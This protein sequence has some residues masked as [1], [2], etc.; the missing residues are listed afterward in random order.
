MRP[1]NASYHLAALFLLAGTAISAAA[2]I[3]LSAT[4]TVQTQQSVNQLVPFQALGAG[5][6]GHQRGDCVKMFS[7][8]AMAEM[9][10]AGLGP[11][12][13]RLRTE[14]GCEVWHWNP[15]G[16]WSDAQ[17]ECGYWISDASPG[18]PINVSYGYRLPRRGNSIDQANNDGYSRLVDGDSASFWKS[19][20]Y[21]DAHFTGESAGANPQWIIIDL[22]KAEPV[23]GLKLHWGQPFAETLRAEYWVGNDPMHLHSDQKGEWRTFAHGEINHG[24]GGDQQTRLE[25]QGRKVRFVRLVLG[26]SSHTAVDS[27]SNDIRDKLGFAI[28][29]IELGTFDQHEKFHDLLTHTA[30]GHKQT[31]V[32][33][34]ST[35]PWHRVTDID[36]RTEQPGLDFI[37]TSPLVQDRKV[38]VPVAVFYET[39]ENAAAEIK[40]L[41]QRNYPIDRIELG[42]EP[43]GQWAIPED[44][45]ALYAQVARQLREE[46]ADLKIGGPSLQS[47]EF[48]LLTWPDAA[49][50]SSWM[51]RFINQLRKAK[52]PFDFFS[53]E[54][55]PFDDIWADPAPQLPETRSRLAGMLSSLRH[56]GVPASIPWLITE[57]GYSVFAGRHEV[58]MEGA[59]FQADT[60]GTFLTEGG[61]E[62][63]LYGYEPNYVEDE[64]K[65]TWGNLMMLQLTAEP[66]RFNRLSTYH[67]SRLIGQEWFQPGTERHQIFRVRMKDEK[68]PVSVYA[69]RRPDGRWSLLAVNRDAKRAAR[70]AVRFAT[71]PGPETGFAG[72]V[73][74]IQFSRAQ[75]EWK[76]DA[77]NGHPVRSLAPARTTRPASADY[78]LPPVLADRLA[79]ICSLGPRGHRSGPFQLTP[80]HP[81]AFDPANNRLPDT[82]AEHWPI[83]QA[84]R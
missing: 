59:L 18:A 74:V 37:L 54:Y 79:R 23:N 33:V 62:A 11:L 57:Y 16:S 82:V 9:L 29:E 64:L 51:N 67:G 20:P 56:D 55:Y 65:C 63:Y 38:M 58:D 36:Y 52:A 14:L 12:S 10:T 75:Y 47:F 78:E 8:A 24:S 43:D 73:D 48:E 66:D 15:R 68:G 61:A 17:H 41:R 5:V 39:P 40:Y 72:S 31:T 25:D 2:S 77:Q 46:K 13:Y 3:S 6:D 53:F 34:S 1:P 19:N 42:E 49:G 50:N 45:A 22:G 60:I 26:K 28:R 69:A 27:S 80:A 83:N 81:G 70:L 84:H 21:L 71:P 44:F 7:E 35:D 30:E 76:D 32:Y 4:V